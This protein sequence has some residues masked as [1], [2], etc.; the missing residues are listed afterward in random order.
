MNYKP[1]LIMIDASL[2]AFAFH[3]SDFMWMKMKTKRFMPLAVTKWILLHDEPA[4]SETLFKK[5]LYSCVLLQLAEHHWKFFSFSFCIQ[6]SIIIKSITILTMLLRELKA[7]SENGRSTV[8]CTCFY[9]WN[10]KKNTMGW[11]VMKYILVHDD[12][13][14]L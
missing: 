9:H 14:S 6:S 12:P 1:I 8:V 5:L 11:A 4:S 10:D 7:H 13:A 2:N 3:N